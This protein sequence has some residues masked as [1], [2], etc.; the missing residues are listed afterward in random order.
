V[1]N[2][3]QFTRYWIQAQPLVANFIGALVPDFAEAEDVLQR[4]ALTCLRKFDR[5]DAQRPFAA[6]TLGIARLEVLHWQRSRARNVLVFD[7]ALL[8][9]VSVVCEE[10]APELD[11]RMNVLRECL[12]HLERRAHEVLRLR[13]DEELKPGAI[14]TRLQVAVVAVRVRLSRARKVLREC[15]ELKLPQEPC[16]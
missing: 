6:W 8:D 16:P 11:R 12:K 5:Y 7:D 2:P 14:A 1:T 4:V 13:Y 3:E 15:I 9:E 10:L